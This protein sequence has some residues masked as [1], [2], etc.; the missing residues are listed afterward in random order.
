MWMWILASLVGVISAASK[1]NREPLFNWYK[2]MSPENVMVAIN[3]GAKEG[4]T[5]MNGVWWRPDHGFQGGVASDAGVEHRWMLPNADVYQTERWGESTFSYFVPFDTN[6]PVDGDYTLVL[7]FSEQ[8]FESPGLKVFDVKVGDTTVIKG[9]DPLARAG[10]KLFPYDAFIE[11]KVKRG[12]V[13][14]NGEKV[15]GA[16]KDGALQVSFVKGP[17][18]NPKVNGIAL[19]RGTAS[20]TH[21]DNFDKYMRT[22]HE[23]RMEQAEEKAKEEALFNEDWYDYDESVDGRGIFN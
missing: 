5:D 2:G 7:K 16:L 21:K 8:Y 23:I 14:I 17:A 4:V 12:E 18:D 22:I 19:V 9:L 15:K 20:K 11:L 3:C 6:V 10:N 1:V 13:L